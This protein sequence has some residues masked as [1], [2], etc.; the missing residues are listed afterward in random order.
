MADISEQDRQYFHNEGNSYSPSEKKRSSASI[1]AKVF[2]YTAIGLLITT[3]V[4]FG[5]GFLI[6]YLFYKEFQDT[7]TLSTVYL[8]ILIGAAVAMLIDM[9]VINFVVIRGKHS[10]LIPGIIYAVLVGVLFSALTIVIDWRI[11]GM[12]FGI[13]T[14]AFLLMALIAFLS[15]G[16][17]APLLIVIIGLSVGVG[18]LALFN[19]IFALATGTVINGL[20]LAVSI[21][22]LALMM[23]VTIYD[24]WRIKKIA[25]DGAMSNNLALYCA[26]VIYTDFINIFVRV[27]YF[28]LI[29]FSNNKR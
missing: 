1:I 25:S 12:A 16:S 26:F 4:A 10:V 7:N 29:I 6:Y 28:L 18:L 22:I 19:W 13:T 8:I 15:K 20:Y 27:L 17:L 14:L 24:M 2:G 23:F 11:L 9:L 5:L 3:V 21:G